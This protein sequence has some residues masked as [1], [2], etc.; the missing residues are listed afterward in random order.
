MNRT[1][2]FPGSFDP[3]TV[4]H[5]DIVKRAL[6]MFDNI[7]VGIGVNSTKQSLYSLERRVEAIG[8]VFGDQ[9]K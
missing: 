5:E 3:I 9:R 2:L 6:S 1:A 7:V 4:G 8:K